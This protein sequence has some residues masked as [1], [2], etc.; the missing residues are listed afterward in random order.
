MGARELREALASRAHAP[1]PLTILA[2]SRL[3][4][5]IDGMHRTT[6]HSDEDWTRGQLWFGT[7][8][9]P[10]HDPRWSDAA[11][12]L[13]IEQ[14][15]AGVSPSN[16]EA[17]LPLQ[18][19]VTRLAEMPHMPMLHSALPL[20]RWVELMQERLNINRSSDDTPL[21]EAIS[22]VEHVAPGKPKLQHDVPATAST[23]RRAAPLDLTSVT[24]G[25]TYTFGQ[26]AKVDKHA[27]RTRAA[28]VFSMARRC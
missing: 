13:L 12:N 8:P 19:R 20:R 25:R 1:L 23:K 9:L 14:A 22:D 4:G 26:A 16:E 5:Y 2:R 18:L 28:G 24:R 7:D 17:T 3:D 15:Y 21:A 11:H 27:Q 6:F 10:R